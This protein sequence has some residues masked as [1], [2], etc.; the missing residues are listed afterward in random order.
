MHML[1]CS[2]RYYKQFVFP[3]DNVHFQ[4]SAQISKA[5]VVQ[6]VDF[7]AMVNVGFGEDDLRGV[8]GMTC[9]TWSLT[10]ECL[11]LF[12]GSDLQYAYF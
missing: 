5:L 3:V 1:P 12:I 4:Q 11:I 9:C 8:V 10:E 6:Q 2:I 7:E